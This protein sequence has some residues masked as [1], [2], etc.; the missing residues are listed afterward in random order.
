MTLW[1]SIEVSRYPSL[2]EFTS[3]TP[4]VHDRMCIREN[5]P[6]VRSKMPSHQSHQFAMI[7]KV[8]QHIRHQNHIELTALTHSKRRECRTVKTVLSRLYVSMQLG[9]SGLATAVGTASKRRPSDLT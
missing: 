4:S 8:V 1:R 2:Q 5:K 9:D 3:F 6:A 7:V